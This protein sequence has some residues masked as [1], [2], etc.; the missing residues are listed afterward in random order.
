MRSTLRP[1]PPLV[2][3]INTK[4]LLPTL[5]RLTGGVDLRQYPLDGPLPPLSP[6]NS[7][8][9]R[10]KLLVELA[11]RENLSIRQLARHYATANGHLFFVGTP[12]AMTEMMDEWLRKV[13]ADGFM[14]LQPYFPTPLDN[15]VRL[16]V[17]ELQRRG[18]F[19]KEYE[20][21]ALRENLGLPPI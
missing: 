8:Q 20:G 10:Q 21:R 12:R 5:S 9:S 7:G 18:V 17:P 6:T 14:L 13:A 3:R 16:V 2:V 15:F 11:Q 19:R 4:L 1:A